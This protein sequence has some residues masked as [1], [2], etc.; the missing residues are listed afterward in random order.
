MFRLIYTA[1]LVSN[2]GVSSSEGI[3]DRPG[4]PT[5]IGSA[6]KDSERAGT[7]RTLVE[8]N[9]RPSATDMSRVKFRQQEAEDD[10]LLGDTSVASVLQDNSSGLGSADQSINNSVYQTPYPARVQQ[11]DPEEVD[12]PTKAADGDKVI[13]LKQSEKVRSLA[14]IRKAYA[15]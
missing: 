4:E 14:F 9:E 5:K 1:E 7:N 10:F 8:S 3:S 2:S 11:F 12:T 6:R 15:H 13:G